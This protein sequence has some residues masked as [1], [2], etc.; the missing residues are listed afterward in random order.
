MHSDGCCLVMR[1]LGHGL[2]LVAIPDLQP[3]IRYRARY[4]CCRVCFGGPDQ[5]QPAECPWAAAGIRVPAQRYRLCSS[6]NGSRRRQQ[7]Q[8]QRWG[9][10][11]LEEPLPAGGAAAGTA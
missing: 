3:E 10:G 4:R 8:Q 11:G 1:C 6:S 7:Q 9:P 2:R 5:Q